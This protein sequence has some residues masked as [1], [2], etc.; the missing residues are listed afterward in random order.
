MVEYIGASTAAGLFDLLNHN[1]T[2]ELQGSLCEG[3]RDITGV[4][5]FLRG[6]GSRYFFI[7]FVRPQGSR[8]AAGLCVR[9]V[10]TSALHTLAVITQKQHD[11]R[12]KFS[13]YA[14]LDARGLESPRETSAA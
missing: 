11:T 4:A 8:A 9:E 6:A 3:P 1:T 14:S 5:D 12:Q 7:F 13:F 2:Q 10:C